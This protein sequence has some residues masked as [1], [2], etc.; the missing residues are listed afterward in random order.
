MAQDSPEIESITIPEVASP[1]QIPTRLVFLGNVDSGKS[2]LIGVLSRDTLDNGRGL[3]RKFVF[4]HPH[5]TSTGRTSSISTEFCQVNDKDIL[6][7]D[8]CGHE[9]YLKTT[10]FGLNLVKPDWCVLVIGANMGVSKMTREHLGTAVS[11]GHKVIVCITKTDICPK[12]IMENTIRDIKQICS[13]VKRRIIEVREP[14][15]SDSPIIARDSPLTPLVR[16]SSVTGENVDLLRNLVTQLRSNNEYPTN[17]DSEFMIDQPYSVKGV[18]IVVA[19]TINR[20]IISAG[21]ILNINLPSGFSEVVVRSIYNE[22][23]E[24]V[25]SIVAGHHC[26]LN[27][28]GK[29]RQI[30]REDVH[31]GMVLVSDQN[32]KLCREFQAVVYIF[33]HSTSIIPKGE[34]RSGYQS[35]IHCNGIR[36]SAE[37]TWIL[38]NKQILRSNEKSLVNFRFRY[39]PEYLVAG[40]RFIFREGFTRG[41]GKIVKLC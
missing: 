6:L 17:C 25:K 29:K 41:V 19:G 18:G 22:R 34:R 7:T 1:E 32:I 15:A 26:T 37:I 20:G 27:I 36:Q 10:L 3:V 2:T 16:I 8:L 12:H 28:R 33:H 24:S 38:G 14:V 31:A 23:D 35:V 11:L 21:D 13:S 4:N 5:E 9:K 30:K 40:S 39:R